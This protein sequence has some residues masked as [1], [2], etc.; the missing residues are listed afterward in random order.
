MNS[1]TPR[2]R[3]EALLKTLTLEEKMYQL[4]AQMVW[5][6][7]EDYEDKRNHKEGNYRNPG[8]FMHFD[9]PDPATPAEVAE[10]INRDVKLT[11]EAHPHPVPPL[12]HGEALHGA[13]WGMAT[14]FPQPI[15]MA[16]MFDDDMVERIADVIGKECAAVGVRQALTPVVNISRDCRW[17]RT[18]ETFGEDVL[19]SSNTGVAVCRGLQKNGVIA[20][21]K[22]YA[23]N[24]SDGGRDSNYSNSSERAMREVWLRP[25]EKCFKE[26]GALS[27]MA[28][29]NSWEGVPCS[30]NDRLLTEILRDE[31]GFEGFV[32]SDYWGVEGV[33]E[34]HKL[35]DSYHR[36]EAVC[37]KAGLDVNLPHSCY[38]KLRKAYDEGLITEEDLDRAVLRVLTAKFVIGLMDHPFAD[39]AAANALVRCDAH[40]QLALE[41]ARR[42][43]ILLKNDGT[44][45]L[46]K[47]GIKKLA[48]FGA[49]ANKLPVGE[50]YSGPFK[51]LWEAPDAKTPLEYLRQYLEGYA[52]V[53]YAEDE[54]IDTVA[55]ECDA[56]LYLTAV[57]EGEGMDR[58]DIR[59]PGVTRKAQADESAIIVG[60]FEIEIKTDQED[61]IRRMTAANKNSTVILLN[62]SPVDMTAW[63]EDCGAVLEAWYPGEQGAQAITEILFGEVNPS[64]KLP[65]T[66]PRSVGQLPLY[67]AAKPSGRG[68]GYVE[69]DGSPL[70]PFG[71]GLSYTTFEMGGITH[72]AAADS[73]T[74]SLNL[75]N[76]GDMDGAE[77]VQVYL[78]GTNCDVVMPR[79]ELKAYRR[80]EVKAGETVTVTLTVLS[81]AFCYYDRK[82][83]LGMHNGDYTVSVGASSA[84]LRGSFAIK[85]RDGKLTEA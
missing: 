48:V 79:L 8:H 31:W 28:A 66:F 32:V 81:E 10:R 55:A 65:I 61:S 62:G 60:K 45:P 43:I 17:G 74:L 73:L 76:T 7:K 9:R 13:Q 63:L 51:R 83:T 40:K 49:G 19:L 54:D 29:Y 23:D 67:Y 41:S 72:T 21:P 15:A 46:R 80:T 3:A 52:E 14:C 56:A 69:N 70:Y 35:V 27:V 85:V 75:T 4:S 26:G 12:E 11:M 36:A 78:T 38:E 22:H 64:A 84:D 6:V 16:S 77:V 33:H 24:Y 82:M 25:F 34:A 18:V 44:L 47:D 5:D 1:A 37:L 20:T 39:P 30:A 59:L 50:N 2:A 68:Y 57:V 53:I 71:Y 58:S 42:S